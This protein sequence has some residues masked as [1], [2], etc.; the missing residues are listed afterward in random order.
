MGYPHPVDAETRAVMGERRVIPTL[1]GTT[2][3]TGFSPLRKNES[4]G[5]R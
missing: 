1:P 5:R 2:T 3:E 4:C